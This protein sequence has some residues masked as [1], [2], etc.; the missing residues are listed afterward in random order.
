MGDKSSVPPHK[1][2]FMFLVSC[3]SKVARRDT[4]TERRRAHVFMVSSTDVALSLTLFEHHNVAR[5]V[6]ISLAT[7]LVH[8]VD[9]VHLHIYM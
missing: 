2:S 6:L 5:F 4:N 8:Y 9:Y 3:R 1:M 7:K